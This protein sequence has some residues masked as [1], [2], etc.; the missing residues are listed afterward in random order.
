MVPSRFSNEVKASRL[1]GAATVF[2]IM[3]KLL[4]CLRHLGLASFDTTTSSAPNA[5]ASAIL[6]GE[7][8]KATVCAPSAWAELHA[9]M[10]EPA[11]AHNADLLAGARAPVAQRRPGGDA[12]AEQRRGRGQVFFGVADVEHEMLVHR[13]GGAIAAIGVGAAADRAVIGAGEADR[14]VAILLQPVLALAN[15]C[16]SCRPCSRPRRSGRA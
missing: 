7:V 4:A 9:H 5:L 10:A 3:S 16:G 13:D 12:G 6:S 14:A 1:C 11:D 15:R 2:R 8:V